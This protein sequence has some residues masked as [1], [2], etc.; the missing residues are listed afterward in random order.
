MVESFCW[1]HVL[2][3]PRVV[4]IL[5]TCPH[6]KGDKEEDEAEPLWL[7]LLCKLIRHTDKHPE[8]IEI[9]K[10]LLNVYVN[11]PLSANDDSRP[12]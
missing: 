7:S 9:V 2:E 6:C 11:F 8:G 12:L 10:A 3:C 1:L 5:Y 4:D